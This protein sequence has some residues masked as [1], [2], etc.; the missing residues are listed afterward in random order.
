[1][2]ALGVV[3]VRRHGDDGLADGV[4]Q[5]TLGVPLE[6]LQDPGADLLRGVLLAVDVDA[7]VRA[8]VALHG[9]DRAVGVGDGLTLGD[10]PHQYLAGLGEADDRGS[11][12]GP[13]GV[14]DDG[15]LPRL[16]HRDD[17]VGGAEVDADGLGHGDVPPK[18]MYAI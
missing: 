7:P 1:G 9:A 8:H 10:L 17:G 12:A 2:L 11:R 18:M 4:A 5:V 16:E 3:E 13:F 14:G 15:G 6:L